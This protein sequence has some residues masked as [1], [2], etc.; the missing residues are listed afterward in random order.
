MS[1][2]EISRCDIPEYENI[3]NKYIEVENMDIDKYKS[4]RLD[5]LSF[6]SKYYTIVNEKCNRK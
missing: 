3:K 5:I 2:I 1:T 6:L 4:M